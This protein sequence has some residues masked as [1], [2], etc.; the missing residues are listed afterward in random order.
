ML[1]DTENSAADAAH[2]EYGDLEKPAHTTHTEYGEAEML[3]HA[4]LK[5]ADITSSE[6]YKGDDS[7]GKIP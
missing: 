7:D 3:P 2:T 6:A 1:K 4:D 5:H